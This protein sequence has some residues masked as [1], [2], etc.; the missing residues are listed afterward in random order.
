M[1]LLRLGRAWGGGEALLFCG[2]PTLALA[3]ALIYQTL[4]CSVCVENTQLINAFPEKHKHQNEMAI[5]GHKTFV[6]LL[7]YVHGKH[8]RSCRDGQLT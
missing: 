3:S 4:S 6:D 2:R 5:Q 7:F 1:E 8:L